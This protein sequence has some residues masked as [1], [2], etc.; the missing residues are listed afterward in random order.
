MYRYW[1]EYSLLQ[2]AIQGMKY[3]GG[4]W[5]QLLGDYLQEGLGDFGTYL[6]PGRQIRTLYQMT[7]KA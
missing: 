5:G 3:D 4:R 2:G 7:G 6:V 1:E